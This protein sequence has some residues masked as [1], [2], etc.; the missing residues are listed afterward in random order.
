MRFFIQQEQVA[1]QA[2]QNLIDAG[3]LTPGEAKGYMSKL[4]KL[5][6]KDLLAVLLESWELKEE[7]KAGNPIR[8]YPID[9]LGM[10]DN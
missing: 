5:D 3:T 4:A 8:S 10:S 6:P 9:Y 2:T 1:R 7:V